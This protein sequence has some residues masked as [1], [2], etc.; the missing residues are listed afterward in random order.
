MKKV[1]LLLLLFAAHQPSLQATS[2]TALE[3]FWNRATYLYDVNGDIVV[4]R[5]VVDGKSLIIKNG[6]VNI[7]MAILGLILGFSFPSAPSIESCIKRP[8]RFAKKAVWALLVASVDYKGYFDA[9]RL[10]EVFREALAEL[11]VEPLSENSVGEA[12]SGQDS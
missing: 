6:S 9:A 5:V 4:T 12:V 10:I 1:L 8:R 2:Q 3:R 7:D 11:S